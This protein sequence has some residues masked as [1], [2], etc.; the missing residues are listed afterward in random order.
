M[1]LA[2][3]NIGHTVQKL[4]DQ[5]ER[6]SYDIGYICDA[7]FGGWRLQKDACQYIGR[8]CET[9]RP[10]RVVEFGSGLSTLLLAHEIKR[11]NIEEVWS[12][13]HLYDFPG[14]P[15]Q[16]IQEVGLDKKV[17]FLHCP[18]RPSIFG[19]KL[20]NFFDIPK[21]L[22]EDIKPVDLVIIDGPPYYFESREAALYAVFAAL[23]KRSL[24]LLD[25]AGRQNYEQV[26]LRNWQRYFGKNIETVIFEKEFKKGLAC[27]WLTGTVVSLTPFPRTERAIASM[28]ATWIGCLGLYHRLRKLF[29]VTGRTPA[30]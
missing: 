7:R 5:S 21:G 28:R 27:V 23:S 4:V 17:H 22:L 11:G 16:R 1:T 9:L 12:I 19:G 30:D 10:R 3:E 13:D 8:I 2:V 15:R 20:F 14:H 6:G 26:Y 29:S 24:V 25:D 18:I